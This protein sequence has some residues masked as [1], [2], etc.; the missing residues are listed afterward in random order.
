MPVKSSRSSVLVWPDAATVREA[1]RAWAEAQLRARPGLVRLG[2]FGSYARGTAGVGSDLDL[3][4]V[5]RESAEPFTRR[6]AR[7]DVTPLPVPA[8]L[9]VYT[10]QEWNALQAQGGRF[11]R[12]L[13]EETDWLAGG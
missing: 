1:A 11:A 6:A 3:V 4:A 12:M 2:V 10:E 5:V 9:L 8:E 13:A 7:W